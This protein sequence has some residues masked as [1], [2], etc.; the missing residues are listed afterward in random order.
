MFVGA[1]ATFSEREKRAL[2]GNT[3]LAGMLVAPSTLYPEAGTLLMDDDMSVA[4]LSLWPVYAEE[5]E[6][7]RQYGAEA[8]TERLQ[9]AG[10]TDLV[11]VRRAN[12][13]RR[14]EPVTSR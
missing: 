10:V 12:V 13:A 14:D 7:A 5:L 1:G 8:L 4:F 6:L 9:R 11:D 3:G 2:A